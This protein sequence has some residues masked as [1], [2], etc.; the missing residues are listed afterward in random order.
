MSREF[1]KL[2]W[3]RC[4]LCNFCCIVAL[5]GLMQQ[6]IDIETFVVEDIFVYCQFGSSV[7]AH[8][9]LC[10]ASLEFNS[11]PG[12]MRP[13]CCCLSTHGRCAVNSTANSFHRATIST[14]APFHRQNNLVWSRM[15][16]YVLVCLTSL[17]N[18]PNIDG[19]R[20]PFCLGTYNIWYGYISIII[21][22]MF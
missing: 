17:S 14:A 10:L 4:K 11:V 6:S 3:L 19:Q 2:L 7:Y 13:L 9:L 12:G 21:W 22:S 1:G 8:L 15:F 18:I 5:F 20:T 16:S